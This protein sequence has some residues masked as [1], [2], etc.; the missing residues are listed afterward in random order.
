M[1][2]KPD[3]VDVVRTLSFRVSVK[4]ADYEAVL[5]P[6]VWPYRVAVRHYRAPRRDG[7]WQGQSG[8]SG[9]NISTEER[10][11]P[12]LGRS[13]GQQSSAGGH[14]GGYHRQVG[15]QHYPPGHAGRVDSNQQMLGQP[16]Q[17]EISNIFVVLAALG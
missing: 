10:R 1:L 16:G 8:K 9:G 5:K 6:E 15:G 3:V 12:K 17:I 11:E 13:G 14:Q 2:T 4:P 7:S